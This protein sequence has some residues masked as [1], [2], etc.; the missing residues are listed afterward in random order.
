ML[1]ELA[2]RFAQKGKNSRRLVFIAFSGEE[3][4]LLGS[5]HYVKNPLFPLVDTVAMLN[6]DMVGRLRADKDEPQKDLLEVWG[7]GTAKTFDKLL[8]GFNKAH[9]FKLKKVPTGSGPSDHSSFYSQKIPVYFF[10]TGTHPDYHK[11]SDTADK[12][13]VAGMK[14]IA[15]LVEEAGAHLMNAAD[16]PEY[17]KV[18]GGPARPSPFDGPRLGIQPGYGEEDGVPVKAV[19]AGGPAAKGGIK[20]GDRIV[21]IAGKPVK[22]MTAYM[23]V[24]GVQKKGESI[25]V[26][27][28]REGKK[29]NVKVLLE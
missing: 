26:G 28:V 14:R 9:N 23:A 20:E 18:Q 1:M 17:V 4:G 21:E 3:S 5:E 25:Q 22:N 19:T 16:R 15:D 13:N 6:M 24:M 8:D 7:T 10:F 12:I 29:V 11:P 27:V 2:R